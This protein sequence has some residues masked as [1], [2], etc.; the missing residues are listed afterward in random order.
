V[1][2]TVFLDGDKLMARTSDQPPVQLVPLAPTKFYF[3]VPG[4]QRA[5]FEVDASGAPTA[6]VLSSGTVSQRAERKR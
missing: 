2:I 4:D 5:E 1:T 6:L 3:K